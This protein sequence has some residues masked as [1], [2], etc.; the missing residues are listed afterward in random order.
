MEKEELER[1]VKF[2]KEAWLE[3]AK[4]YM[5]VMEKLC[6]AEEEIY[7]LARENDKLLKGKI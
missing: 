4:N 3:T 7:N 1:Q 5:F 6:D 2:Y